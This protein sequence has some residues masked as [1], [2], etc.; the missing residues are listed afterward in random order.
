MDDFPAHKHC[1]VCGRPIGMEDRT[2]GPV[3]A[4]KRAR[5]M[6]SRTLYT[7]LFLI[8]GIVLIVVILFGP[9]A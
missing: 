2:C 3:C 1:P 9:H 8:M 6:R 5:A 4:E 7:Y